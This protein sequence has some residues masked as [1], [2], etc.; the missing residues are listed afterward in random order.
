M[1]L[2]FTIGAAS[3]RQGIRTLIPLGGTALAGRL[4]KPYPTTFRSSGPPGSRTPI[5]G[6]QS[7]C[8]PVG[9][10]AHLRKGPPENRTRSP[11]LPRRCAAGTPADPPAESRPGRTRTCANLCVRQA[12]WPLDDGTNCRKS[13]GARAYGASPRPRYRAGWI[14][15]MKAN[16]AP[17]LPGQFASTTDQS[18]GGDSNSHAWGARAA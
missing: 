2:L 12:S 1:I 11:S 3:G 16:R 10:A 4:G 7:W 14:G 18:P 9:P 13:A 17:A 8:R 5:S 15:L 6:V